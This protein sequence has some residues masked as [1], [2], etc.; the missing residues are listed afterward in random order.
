MEKRSL[1]R[2]PVKFQ[3]DFFYGDEMYSGTVKNISQKGM[4]IKTEMC[5]PSESKF[6]V[7]LPYNEHV[8]KVPVKVRSL[9]KTGDVYNGMGVEVF[10]SSP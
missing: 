9:V 7:L 2:I 8:L 3:A 6:E 4:Y 1:E 5:P 10:N